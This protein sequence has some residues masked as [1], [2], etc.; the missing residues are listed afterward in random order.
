M[1]GAMFS[2]SL[3]QYLLMGG[4]VFPAAIYLRPNYGAGNEDNDKLPPSKDPRHVLLQSMPPQ[5]PAEGHHRPR[6]LLK[7]LRHPQASLLWGHCSFLLG[8]GAQGSVVPSKSL[9]LSPV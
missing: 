4:A 7:T 9:F 2:K 3:I 1:G 6:P 8:P 5:N